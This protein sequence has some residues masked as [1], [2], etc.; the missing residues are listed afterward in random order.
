[1]AIGSDVV[2]VKETR[3]WVLTAVLAFALAASAPAAKPS[4]LHPASAGALGLAAPEATPPGLK[5]ILFRPSTRFEDVGTAFAIQA[6]DR[7]EHEQLLLDAARK[8]V[9]PRATGRDVDKPDPPA[10]EA[11]RH[12]HKTP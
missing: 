11:C 9:G 5:V 7:G 3:N 1:M 12:I 4:G 10:A 8:A 2:G 6:A